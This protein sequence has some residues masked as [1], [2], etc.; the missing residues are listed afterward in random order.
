MPD[1]DQPPKPL[2]RGWFHPFAA[3]ASLVATMILLYRT[4]HDPPRF[5]ALLI[6]GVSMV[7]LF[8]VSSVYHIGN[9]SPRVRAA[10][11]TFDHSNIYLLIAGTYTP[12]CVVVLTGWMR[13][14]V[15]ALVWTVAVAGISTSWISTKLPKWATSGIYIAMGWIA[16]IPMPI[17][18]DRLPGLA[19]LTFLLGGVTYTI[20]GVVYAL[21]RPNPFPRVFGYHEIFHLFVVAGS[22]FF[23]AMVWIWIVPY[24]RG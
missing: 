9:W 22:A 23:A 18:I 1:T 20:G 10:L 14:F 12:I 15:L 4:H 16:L 17:L 19:M 3:V 21:K 13:V 8:A 6:F 11:R 7:L 5:V 24:P 2:L